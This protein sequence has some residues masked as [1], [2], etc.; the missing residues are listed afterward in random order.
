MMESRLRGTTWMLGARRIR[1][2]TT[3]SG[4]PICREGFR[5]G[6]HMYYDHHANGG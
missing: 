6:Y 4:I 2:A 5:R 3:I 1:I